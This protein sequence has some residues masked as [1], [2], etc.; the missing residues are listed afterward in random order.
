MA[1]GCTAQ[2][3][4]EPAYAPGPPPPPVFVSEA[5]PPDSEEV[6]VDVEPPVVNIEAYPSAVYGG[7]T[8]YYVGGVW[9]RRAPHGWARYRDEPPGLARVRV[10]HTR[11][12]RWAREGAPRPAPRSATEMQRPSR[13]AHREVRP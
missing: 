1:T 5:P 3:T 7:V 6:V 13:P 9:Y 8:V 4:S 11:E 2:V 10:A 12:A